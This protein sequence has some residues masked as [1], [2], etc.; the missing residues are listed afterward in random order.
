MVGF[1]SLTQRQVR[2]LPVVQP[3]QSLTIPRP[4]PRPLCLS[5]SPLCLI[6][7]GQMTDSLVGHAASVNSLAIDPTSSSVFASVG[8]D[9]STRVWDLE[10]KTCIQE[11]TLH[12]R[13]ADQ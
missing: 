8:D 9:C 11:W 3:H 10:S 1:A 6:T 7:P 12:R 5:R 2:A 4:L 13:K